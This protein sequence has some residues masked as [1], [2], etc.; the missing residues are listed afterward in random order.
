[1][2]GFNT[3]TFY[4]IP[5]INK[6]QEEPPGR[7]IVSAIRGPLERVRKYIDSLINDLVS[8]VPSYVRDMGNVLNKNMNLTF[9]GDVLLVGIDVESLYTSIPHEWG[10]SAVYTFLEKLFPTMGAQNEFVIELLEIALKNNFF[11]FVGLNYQQIQGTSMGAPWAPSYACLH[12]GC[13]E[14]EV[15]YAST[16]YLGHARTWLRYI[17]NVLVIW[18]GSRADLTAFMEELGHN[19]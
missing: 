12:L 19:T 1:M 5:K 15:V 18:E 14:E 13:W 6:N 7:P 17:N 9:P 16:M 2:Y 3:P 11:Q 10:I 8:I 4:M